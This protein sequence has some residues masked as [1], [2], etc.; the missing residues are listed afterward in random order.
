MSLT[1]MKTVGTESITSTNKKFEGK[2][3]EFYQG[4]F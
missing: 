4:Q 1:L 3:L 2:Q